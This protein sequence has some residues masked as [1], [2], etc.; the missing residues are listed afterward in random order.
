MNALCATC[1]ALNGA[2][3]LVLPHA[4]RAAQLYSQLSAQV[5][6]GDMAASGNKVLLVEG[7][8]SRDRKSVV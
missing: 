2:A 6:L 3:L 8:L 5:H 7:P 4:C 1:L